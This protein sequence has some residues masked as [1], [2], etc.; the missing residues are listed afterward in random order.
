MRA[1][2]TSAFQG[3]IYHTDEAKGSE[4]VFG[5]HGWWIEMLM[6]CKSK[7]LSL[8]Q[9]MHVS[10]TGVSKS[11][12]RGWITR[13]STCKSDWQLVL[14]HCRPPGWV[15]FLQGHALSQGGTMQPVR[16]C[17]CD[18]NGTVAHGTSCPSLPTASCHSSSS[19]TEHLETVGVGHY[20]HL[21][22]TLAAAAGRLREDSNLV[23]SH[24][25][26]PHP[27]ACQ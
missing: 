19:L 13:L 3:K 8:G 15:I 11:C 16:Q 12:W 9:T 1:G 6:A 5:G 25:L 23:V 24:I 20:Y 18:S 22:P 4:G 2:W 10:Q 26:M 21:E 27:D 7:N 14:P 17:N